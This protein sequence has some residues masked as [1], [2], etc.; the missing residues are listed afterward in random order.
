LYVEGQG[1]VATVL[2]GTGATVQTSFHLENAGD[3]ELPWRADY[4]PDSSISVLPDS[5]N[6]APGSG[7]DVLVSVDTTSFMPGM[8]RNPLTL[9]N[10]F[11]ESEPDSQTGTTGKPITLEVVSDLSTAPTLES[12]TYTAPGR[13]HLSWSFDPSTSP[14][15]LSGYQIYRSLN[16]GLSWQQHLSVADISARQTDVTGLPEGLVHFGLDAYGGSARTPMSN[17][18]SANVLQG[19]TAATTVSVLNDTGIDWGGDYPSG[20]NA[21]CTSN[22][23]A[24]QDCHEGRDATH[25]DDADGHA[26]FS[27]T[28]LDA[29]GNPLPVGATVWSC[30]RDNVTGLTWEV[31]TDDGGIHDKDNSYRWGGKTAE[32]DGTWG[33]YYDDWDSLVD[34][35]NAEELCGFADWRVP[36]INELEN[37]ASRDRYSPAIDTDYF[38]NTRASYY[39]SS[40]PYASY[41]GGAWVV[42]F[43]SGHSYYVPRY[44]G[45]YVRLVR[46]GE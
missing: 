27:F 36:T 30:V 4:I 43:N 44:D 35:S 12:A 13:V 2:E 19:G 45:R 8:Y 20:N 21:T 23:A 16:G 3:V 24:P 28:K 11:D 9:V 17:V 39:W 7:V 18:L 5:G 34:G 10:A 22:V 6:L 46:S 33:T 31:K 37:L 42:N 40:S 25:H 26:G 32:G 41:S 15:P 1:I 14:V 38:P 29:D